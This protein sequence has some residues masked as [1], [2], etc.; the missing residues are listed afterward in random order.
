MFS[1]CGIDFG[2]KVGLETNEKV[3]NDDMEN[4]LHCFDVVVGNMGV[5][6]SGNPRTV[7]RVKYSFKAHA[8]L[9]RDVYHLKG[10][11]HLTLLGE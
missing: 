10:R 4:D 5:D 2:E 11:A 9:S 3:A 1:Y 6:Q 7:G 8:S